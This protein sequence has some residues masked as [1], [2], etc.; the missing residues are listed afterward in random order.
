MHMNMLFALC[1]MALLVAGCTAPGQQAAPSGGTPPGG[2]PSGGQ[3]ATP[4]SGGTPSGGETKTDLVIEEKTVTSAE[5]L[6]M[7][8]LDAGGCVVYLHP[9]QGHVR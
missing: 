9:A 7:P 1:V 2:E 8:M 4:P 5:T 6:T 3:Q